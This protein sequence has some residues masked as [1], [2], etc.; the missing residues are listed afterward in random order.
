MVIHGPAIE[1]KGAIV[2]FSDQRVPPPDMA[3][4]LKRKGVAVR[5][6]HPCTM[7]LHSRLGVVA[8]TRASFAAYNDSSD[9]DVLV[10]AIQY[11]R[12]ILRRD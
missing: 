3:E 5:A 4:L 1:H 10:D 2:S 8:T 7:P 12:K 6:G 9:V 11:A